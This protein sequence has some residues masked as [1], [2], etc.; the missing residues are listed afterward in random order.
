VMD[1]AAFPTSVG[2]NPSATIL[3]VAEYKIEKFLERYGHKKEWKPPKDGA[4]VK[5]WIAKHGGPDLDP[6]NR[7]MPQNGALSLPII[8]LRFR[9]R[10]RG[11]STPANEAGLIDQLERHPQR[12]DELI[13]KFKNAEDRGIGDAPLIDVR[14][15]ATV[16]DLAQL[17]STAPTVTPTTICLAGFAVVGNNRFK[18]A[19]DS[20][21]QMFVTPS[22]KTPHPLRFFRYKLFLD[23]AAG[24][25]TWTL[26]GRKVLRDDPGSDMW[27]DTSTLFF[28]MAGTNQLHRGILRL[29]L[30][31]FLR[32]Q[33]P[34]MRITGTQD[35]TRKSLALLA[36]Y[37]YFAREIGNIYAERAKTLVTLFTDAMRSLN[38]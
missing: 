31:D 22:K 5:D 37:K 38:V 11:F 6:L 27:L 20:Y 30:Q 16:S 10:M 1:A 36:F 18:L 24:Q 21:L 33:L 13:E 23:D 34:S 3:A 26:D 17:V 29:S 35:P 4:R 19:N 32:M 12:I 25:R 15:R 7:A 8:G 14:V 2:V 9:E 28:E